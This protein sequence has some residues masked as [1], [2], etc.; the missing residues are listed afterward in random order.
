MVNYDGE[1][2]I[3]QDKNDF[4]EQKYVKA[5]SFLEGLNNDE[6]L[7]K[8]LRQVE[9]LTPPAVRK[10]F[11]PIPLDESKSYGYNLGDTNVTFSS[12]TDVRYDLDFSDVT[13]DLY[14]DLTRTT[15]VVKNGADQT[16]GNLRKYQVPYKMVSEINRDTKDSSPFTNDGTLTAN[17]HWRICYNPDIP[18]RIQPNW[19]REDVTGLPEEGIAY[20]IYNTEIPCICRGQTFKPKVTGYLEGVTVN[21][22]ASIDKNNTGSPL[23]V[24]IRPTELV[25]GVPYPKQFQY[26]MLAEQRVRFDNSTPEIVTITFDKPAYVYE[27][28]SYAVCFLSPL[29]HPYNAFWL[30]GWSRNCGADPYLDGDAFYSENNGAT[31]IRYGKDDES[32]E[33]HQGRYAPQDFGFEMQIREN[34]EELEKNKD[35]WLYLKPFYSNEVRRVY[36][37]PEDNNNDNSCVVEWQ[38]SNN[39]RTWI[40]VPRSSHMVNFDSTTPVTFVRARLRSTGEVPAHINSFTVELQTERAL[41]MYAR[42]NYYRPKTTPMLG[43]NLWGR[44]IAPFDLN[45]NDVSKVDC[46][47][48]IISEK[49]VSD[50]YEVITVSDLDRYIFVGL[51]ETQIKG[52]TD[53]KRAKYLQE[54]PSKIE[55]LKEYNVYVLPHNHTNDGW[56]TFFQYFEFRQEPA[57]PI[58]ECSFNPTCKNDEARFYNEWTDFIY[59]YSETEDITKLVP[60]PEGK[61]EECNIPSNCLYWYTDILRDMKAGTI[62][63]VYNPL[64]ISGLTKSE[65]SDGFVLDY[66][67][68]NIPLGDENV[69]S[70]TVKLRCSPLDPIR[71]CF[72]NLDKSDEKEL[73]EDV[74]YT[75]DYERRIITFEPGLLVSGYT[76]TVVYTPNIDDT[77]LA[78]GYYAERD[79]ESYNCTIKPL[80]MEYKV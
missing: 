2:F 60:T 55:Q 41:K 21:L 78:V 5:S 38:V 35:F 25:D 12:T 32:L 26:T 45:V 29:T 11:K 34:H 24:Q 68:E 43:A 57:Y 1:Y 65:V 27:G 44:V 54:N 50:T 20:G 67:K 63:V 79:K 15:A 22:K 4:G 64:I 8:L 61:T 14:V 3:H 80:S 17:E 7:L 10:R 19:I 9:Y 48:E 66:M 40:T 39:G 31:W 75:V 30:G 16:E 47:V 18:Y 36:L 28:V 42:T 56:I 13:T 23:L 77:G 53:D 6:Y 46:T 72:L 70:R 71:D 33:Y 51:D 74:D 62:R 58:L 37:Y 73:V 59:N 52:K 69:E 49:E 76:L